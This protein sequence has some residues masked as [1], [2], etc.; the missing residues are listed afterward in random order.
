MKYFGILSRWGRKKKRKGL[1]VFDAV[2]RS[3]IRVQ[4]FSATWCVGVVRILFGAG[5]SQEQ[6]RCCW[7]CK[8]AKEPADT[9]ACI[10]EILCNRYGMVMRVLSCVCFQ[11]KFLDFSFFRDGVV[12]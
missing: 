1:A 5:R 6:E 3:L 12:R 11:D 10:M 2:V 9:S 4:P 8:S 7:S